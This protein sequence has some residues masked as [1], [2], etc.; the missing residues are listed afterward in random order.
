MFNKR[1]TQKCKHSKRKRVIETRSFVYTIVKEETEDSQ[2]PTYDTTLLEEGNRQF[3]AYCLYC[4]KE[5]PLSKSELTELT[6]LEVE[7]ED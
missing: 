1:N 3:K 2:T 5:I 4:N 7:E 6:T